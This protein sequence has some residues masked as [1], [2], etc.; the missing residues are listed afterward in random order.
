[1]R[2]YAYRTIT[3]QPKSGS[4]LLSVA[5]RSMLAQKNLAL[6][7]NLPAFVRRPGYGSMST[8]GF[9]TP[10]GSTAALAALRAAAKASGRCWSY[11]GR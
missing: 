4:I 9:N 6:S 11:Q 7:F 1:M 10:L 8:P 3:T 5:S 2:V